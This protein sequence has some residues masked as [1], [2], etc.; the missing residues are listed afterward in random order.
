MMLSSLTQTFPDPS[1][2]PAGSSALQSRISAL[3]TLLDKANT[4]IA[5]K[6]SELNDL[7]LRHDN[8]S[9]SSRASLAHLSG[10]LQE[11]KRSLRHTTQRKESAE[12][13]EDL[14]RKEVEMLR[15]EPVCY[16]LHIDVQYADSG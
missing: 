10:E 5:K 1:A 11:T 6:Q 9:E 13:R 12:R 7:Q 14:L 3:T 4:D 16:A 15:A 8:L 2:L